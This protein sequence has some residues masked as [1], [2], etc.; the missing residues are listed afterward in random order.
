MSWASSA[1][2]IRTFL[3]AATFLLRR[4]TTELIA[5]STGRRNELVG[6]MSRKVNCW[7]NAVMERFFLSLKTERAW[8]SDYANHAEAMS[9]TNYIMC[10]YNSM[11]LHFKLDIL[12][13]NAFEL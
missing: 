11:R 12:P 10:F 13:S 6:S 3:L 2:T 5:D 9:D 4:C 1:Q 8:Q 7:H